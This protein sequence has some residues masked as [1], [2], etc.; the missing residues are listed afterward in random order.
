MKIKTKI[1][2]IT[3]STN[4]DPYAG[5]KVYGLSDDG[6]VYYWEWKTGKWELYKTPIPC[7]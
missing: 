1:I 2:Q 5:D 4:N 7:N 6:E 3:V